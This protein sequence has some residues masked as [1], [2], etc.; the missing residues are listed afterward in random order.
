[1]N[2]LKEE[3]DRKEGLYVRTKELSFFERL[4]FKYVLSNWNIMN[5]LQRI[6]F[7]ETAITSDTSC[8]KTAFIT[9]S[10]RSGKT[11]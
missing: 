6:K 3:Q 10:I 7:S 11:G 4:L 8:Q 1:M 5:W 2:T 9:R